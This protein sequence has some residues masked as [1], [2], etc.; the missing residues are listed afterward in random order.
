MRRLLCFWLVVLSLLIPIRASGEAFHLGFYSTDSPPIWTPSMP[1]NGLGGEILDAIAKDARISFGIDYLPLKRYEN[2]KQGNRLGNPLFFVGQEFAAVI[3]LLATRAGFCYYQPQHP[4]G[5]RFRSLMDLYGMTLG[6]IRGTIANK[7]EFALYGVSIE[8][9]TTLEGL[10]NKL[11]H[12]RIDVA[13]V[14]DITAFYYMD[15]L[16]PDERDNFQFNALQGGE[17]PIAIMLDKNTPG[18]DEL[19][20]RLR[21]SLR[22]ILDDGRYFRIL[23]GYAYGKSTIDPDWKKRIE[24]ALNQYRASPIVI[25][26]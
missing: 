17:T 11:R 8:E 16:F 21:Q 9:N 4:D 26:E 13:F 6:V 12:G 14:I 3:P 25:H 10:F 19:A 20:K 2:L 15:K 7:E 23:T 5:K 22:K 24:Q 18:T 1:A